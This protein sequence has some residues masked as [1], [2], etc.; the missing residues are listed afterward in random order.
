M[1]TDWLSDDILSV[2]GWLWLTGGVQLITFKPSRIISVPQWLKHSSK[3]HC[4]SH[5]QLEK[6]RGHECS[7]MGKLCSCSWHSALMVSLED[8]K[9]SHKYT[10][11]SIIV[12][13]TR[14]LTWSGCTK[15][16]SHILLKWKLSSLLGRKRLMSWSIPESED[17]KIEKIKYLPFRKIAAFFLFFFLQYRYLHSSYAFAVGRLEPDR[18]PLFHRFLQSFCFRF[19]KANTLIRIPHFL[20]HTLAFS[21]YEHY[22]IS[23]DGD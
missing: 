22:P 8:G 18:K 16:H 23:A 19:R 20:F 1:E 7:S 5:S 11:L 14:F 10:F 12:A 2:R 15:V 21:S 13:S 6:T 3:L 17:N 9:S 4:A